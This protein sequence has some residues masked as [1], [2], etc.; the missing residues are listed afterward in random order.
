[1][2]LLIYR[3]HDVDVKFISH[4]ESY[5]LK[6]INTNRFFS[7]FLSSLLWLLGQLN[8]GR[9]MAAKQVMN[10]LFSAIGEV[11]AYGRHLLCLMRSPY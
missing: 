9:D 11:L 3:I 5:L 2:F 7:F 8:C 6:A 1:M 10:E 4:T